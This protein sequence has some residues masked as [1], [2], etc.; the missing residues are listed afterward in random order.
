MVSQNCWLLLNQV[1]RVGLVEKL[2]SEE[3]LQEGEAGGYAS[4][5]GVS[6][7]SEGTARG[8][9]PRRGRAGAFENSRTRWLEGGLLQGT[10]GVEI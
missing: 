4:V 1:V 5:W 2:T 7:S 6:P 8:K 3:K 10:V 9:P